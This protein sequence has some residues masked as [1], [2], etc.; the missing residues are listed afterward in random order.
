VELRRLEGERARRG[1]A[2]RKRLGSLK[3]QSDRGERIYI[4]F[5]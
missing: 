2:E 1:K 5:I 4:F 3:M